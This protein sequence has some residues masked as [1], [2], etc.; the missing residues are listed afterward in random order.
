MAQGCT[1]TESRIGQQG[2]YHCTTVQQGA[3]LYKGVYRS[4]KKGCRTCDVYL[5]VSGSFELLLKLWNYTWTQAGLCVLRDRGN[6]YHRRFWTGIM[7]GLF[8]CLWD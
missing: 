3:P 6:A 8:V 1:H 5:L 4:L 7:H 2:K